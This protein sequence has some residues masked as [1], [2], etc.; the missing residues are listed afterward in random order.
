MTFL[1]GL[2]ETFTCI[3]AVHPA[4]DTP[5]M[6]R[7]NWERNG[8]Q[9]RD[10]DDGRV[11]VTSVFEAVAGSSGRYQITITFNPMTIDDNGIYRCPVA[12]TPQMSEFVSEHASLALNLRRVNVQGMFLIEICK[13]SIVIIPTPPPPT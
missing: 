7:G 11:S 3:V 4:V 9:L 1:P 2:V 13:L 6:V 12:V 8:T 5:V 10:S